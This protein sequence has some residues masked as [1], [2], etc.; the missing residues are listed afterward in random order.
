[1]RHC[2][3]CGSRLVRTTPRFGSIPR[4]LCPSCDDQEVTA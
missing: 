1:M 3:S 4:D 2:P